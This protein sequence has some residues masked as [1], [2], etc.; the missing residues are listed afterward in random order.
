VTIIHVQQVIEVICKM[1]E[2]RDSGLF[3]FSR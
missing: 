3:L 2:S 1:A